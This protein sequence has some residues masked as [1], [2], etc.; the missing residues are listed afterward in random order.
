M[1]LMKV[2]LAMQEMQ[3]LEQE[4]RSQTAAVSDAEQ[5]LR[6]TRIRVHEAH[7]GYWAAVL[8]TKNQQG[9]QVI[10]QGLWDLYPNAGVFSDADETTKGLL[11]TMCRAGYV[12]SAGPKVATFRLTEAG[13]V[14]YREGIRTDDLRLNQGVQDPRCCA[15]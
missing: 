12:E 7:R 4:E 13:I 14:A 5:R 11:E 9:V 1:S 2:L 6:A 8:G 3:R 15:P 10:L